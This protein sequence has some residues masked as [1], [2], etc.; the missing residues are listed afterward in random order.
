MANNRMFLVHRPT[1]LAV[2]LGKRMGWGWYDAP[3]HLAEQMTLL[4]AV[5]ESEYGYEGQQDAFQVAMESPES[6]TEGIWSSWT[7]Q[8]R[9]DDGL[10]VLAAQAVT[11]T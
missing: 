3:A 7:T 5:L 1:G 9:R 6:E 8:T 4:Y 11:A 10:V 2:Y